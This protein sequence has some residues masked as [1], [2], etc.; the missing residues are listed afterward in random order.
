MEVAARV[1]PWDEQVARDYESLRVVGKAAAPRLPKGFTPRVMERA[2]EG[3]AD[4]RAMDE[5]LTIFE[6]SNYSP[7]S[8]MR[9]DWIAFTER[10]STLRGALAAEAPA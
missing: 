9:D 5:A 4:A 6:R 7:A 8:T 2:L 1:A 3:R 10:A